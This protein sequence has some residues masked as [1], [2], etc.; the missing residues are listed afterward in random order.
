M[1]IIMMSYRLSYVDENELLGSEQKAKNESRAMVP[2]ICSFLD[3]SIYMN[4]MPKS[5]HGGVRHTY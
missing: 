3:I 2:K 1:K 5:M 4:N